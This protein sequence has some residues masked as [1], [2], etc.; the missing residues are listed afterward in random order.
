MANTRRGKK[1]NSAKNSQANREW[2]EAKKLERKKQK[3]VLGEPSVSFV[4]LGTAQTSGHW[5]K[6]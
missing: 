1:I 6:A 3:W 4:T 5:E 2:K